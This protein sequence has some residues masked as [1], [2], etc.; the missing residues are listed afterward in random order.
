MS[1]RNASVEIETTTRDHGYVCV[2]RAWSN[3]FCGTCHGG[4]LD[5]LL[6]RARDAE[7]GTNAHFVV[8]HGVVYNQGDPG[9]DVYW[10]TDTIA[11]LEPHLVKLAAHFGRRSDSLRDLVDVLVHHRQHAR[12]EP[13]TYRITRSPLFSEA[14][15]QVARAIA[16]NE[17]AD[18]KKAEQLAIANDLA[19]RGAEEK[20]RDVEIRR[21]TRAVRRQTTRVAA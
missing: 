16:A 18:A 14:P 4:I 19:A 2:G 5:A 21:P 12:P 6:C 8:A 11:E 15:K 13:T 7:A 9:R 20:E 1:D 17:A 10:F 3:E